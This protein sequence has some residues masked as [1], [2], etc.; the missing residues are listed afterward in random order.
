MRNAA[1]SNCGTIIYLLSCVRRKRS[2]PAPARDLYTSPWFR[3]ARAYADRTG[4]PWFVLSAKYGLIHPRDVIEPYDLTLNAMRKAD[5]RKWASRVL[6]QL[7]PH[8]DDAKAVVF[9]AGQR[10]RKCL[11]PSLRSRGLIV[12]VPMEG[13]RIGEQLRWLT[14]ELPMAERLA[15]TM[16]FYALLDCLEAKVGGRRLLSNRDALKGLPSRG[17]YFFFEDGE[18]RSGSGSGDR[19][20]R[21]GTHA[22]RANS[23][24]TLSSRLSQHRSGNRHS[25]IFRE[26]VGSALAERSNIPLNETDITEY[27]GQMPFL[28]LNVDDPPGPDSSRGLIER[29]AIALLSGYRR[30]ALDK[31]S[32][33]WLGHYSDRERVRL[34][35]LWN[36]NHVDETYDP[37]FLDEMES[38]I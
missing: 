35:G 31:S 7:E 19:V 34:S 12:Y 17:V 37:P 1:R 38:W 28:W 25:S 30:P 36:N 20:V 18:T 11:K 29:N 4:R 26:L 8:L 5:R 13:L 15:D 22:L 10:Y 14:K 3:K 6:T 24:S 16:L 21:V 2:G 27:I 32:K 33:E 9:L 23:K